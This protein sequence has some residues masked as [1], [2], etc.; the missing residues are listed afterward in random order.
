MLDPRLLDLTYPL[1]CRA[2]VEDGGWYKSPTQCDSRKRT[3]HWISGTAQQVF[4]VGVTPLWVEF[5]DR[6]GTKYI[7]EHSAQLIPVA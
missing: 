7:I 6:H 1:C 3:G 5:L 2:F 4:R